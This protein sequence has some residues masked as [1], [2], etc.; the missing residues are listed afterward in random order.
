MQ[1]VTL[2]IKK[3]L[4]DK[5]ELF[6]VDKAYHLAS[7]KHAPALA[8]MIWEA[9]EALKEGVVPEKL[10]S[11]TE[12]YLLR[13]REQHPL[14]IF[15]VGNSTREAVL[16]ELAAYRLD[17]RSFAMVPPCALA[18]LSHAIFGGEKQGTF[19]LFMGEGTNLVFCNPH[20]RYSSSAVRRIATFDMRILN[21]DRH[22]A[23]FVISEDDVFPI[24]HSLSL[25]KF[26][27]NLCLHF[28]WMK[29][30]QAQTP[31]THEERAYVASLDPQADYEMLVS[32]GLDKN[33]AAFNFASTTLLKLGV[34]QHKTAYEIGLLFTGHSKN[35][36][37]VFLQALEKLQG[38]EK[39]FWKDVQREMESLCAL[40]I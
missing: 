22:F 8:S 40:S 38:C 31:F 14:A 26:A 39:M 17:H 35:E 12:V 23:N 7:L 36:P 13:D 3:L 21:G 30:S 4:Q 33:S 27:K 25:P 20:Q 29:W 6:Q 1:D 19:H 37:S 32:L 24:D 34:A 2:K 15:K 10:P 28:E 9:K 18:T 11:S 16:K 5:P